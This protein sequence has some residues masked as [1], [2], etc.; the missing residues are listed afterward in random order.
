MNKVSF[1]GIT[2]VA[3]FK[4]AAA[5]SFVRGTDE[6]IPVK[7][8]AAQTVAKCANTND[9]DG[10]LETIDHDNGF[11]AV[12]IRGVKTLVYSGDAPAAGMTVLVADGTGKVKTAETGKKYLVLDINT[13]AKTV[14][15]L[16]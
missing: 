10:V 5:S 2:D 3:T 16:M 14:T 7:V 15:F 12:R 6:G 11:G 4:L 8:S 9:F 13:T 1:E